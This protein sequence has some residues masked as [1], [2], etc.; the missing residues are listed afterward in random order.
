MGYVE[1]N[2]GFVGIARI[3][4]GSHSPPKHLPLNLDTTA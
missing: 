1:K 3:Y 4:D 2:D